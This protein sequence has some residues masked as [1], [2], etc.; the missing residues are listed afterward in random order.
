VSLLSLVVEEHGQELQSG[1][2]FH[3][4]KWTACFLPKDGI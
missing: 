1:R 2:R 3:G 4:Q